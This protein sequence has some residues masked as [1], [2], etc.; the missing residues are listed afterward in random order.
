MGN[1]TEVRDTTDSSSLATSQAS[2][3]YVSIGF[4]QGKVKKKSQGMSNLTLSDLS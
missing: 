2:D 1:L 3:V 4:D